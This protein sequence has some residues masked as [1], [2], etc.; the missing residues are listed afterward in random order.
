[1]YLPIWVI[2]VIV[3]LGSSLLAFGWAL[4]AGQFSDQGRARYL[5]LRDE[6][7]AQRMGGPG[8]PALRAHRAPGT[9]GGRSFGGREP[10]C[11]RR[12]EFLG[13][14]NARHFRLSPLSRRPRREDGG[15]HVKKRRDAGMRS[16]AAA[17]DGT[18][19]AVLFAHELPTL[20]PGALSGPRARPAALHRLGEHPGAEERRRSTS[21]HGTRRK[22]PRGST[23]RLRLCGSPRLGFLVHGRDRHEG[24]RFLTETGPAAHRS[25]Y[26]APGWKLTIFS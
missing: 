6:S 13:K 4:H 17:K 1:M 2:L 24:R 22:E 23:A 18:G 10:P 21:R 9:G 19:H 26:L 16:P 25:R 8:T 7:P 20:G 5:A 12:I 11:R 15:G 14:V 3:S